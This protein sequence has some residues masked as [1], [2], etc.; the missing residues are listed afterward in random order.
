LVVQAA[1]FDHGKLFVHGG[2]LPNIVDIA[3]ANRARAERGDRLLREPCISRALVERERIRAGDLAHEIFRIGTSHT[4]QRRLPGEIG[5]EPAGIFTPD[6]RE[7]DHYRYT[8]S[9]SRR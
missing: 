3:S 2:I 6:L 7:V 4:R 1:Y 5:Y 8:T 9:S